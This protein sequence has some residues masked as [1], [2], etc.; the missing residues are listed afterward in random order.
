MSFRFIRD[1]AVLWPIRLMRR[2]LKVPATG[3]YAWRNRPDSARAVANRALLI[4]V[5]RLHA[6]HHGRYGSPRMHAASC[7]RPADKPGT[8]RAVDAAPW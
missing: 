6:D 2:V 7:R 1:H 3:Y 4:D 5:R 8:C